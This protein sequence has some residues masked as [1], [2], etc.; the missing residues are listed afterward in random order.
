[1]GNTGTK[2][3]EVEK[4]RNSI[5]TEPDS[6]NSVVASDHLISDDLEWTNNLDLLTIEL[7][8]DVRRISG[9][10][11]NY[12][13]SDPINTNTLTFEHEKRKRMSSQNFVT[14]P[15]CESAERDSGDPY[16]WKVP[17]EEIEVRRCR[18]RNSSSSFHSLPCIKFDSKSLIN[19]C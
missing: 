5:R 10:P 4:K 6:L 16:T 7:H 18:E 2:A 11:F 12:Y 9:E 19:P 17:V 1:M 13:Q 14:F 15:S 8:D 3:R